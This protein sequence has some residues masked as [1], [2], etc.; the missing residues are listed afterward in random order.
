MYE[1]T[2]KKCDNKMDC[3]KGM[4]KL[5][6]LTNNNYYSSTS[7]VYQ[8]QIKQVEGKR[9]WKSRYPFMKQSH[10]LIMQVHCCTQVVP[11]GK[12]YKTKKTTR[13]GVDNKMMKSSLLKGKYRQQ[14]NISTCA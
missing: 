5:T 3:Q 11:L 6:D 1:D 10:F 14:N 4:R 8:N 7:K 12:P 13:K 2:E 9:K